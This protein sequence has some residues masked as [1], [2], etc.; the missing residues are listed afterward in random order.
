MIVNVTYET[1]GG[2]AFELQLVET[3]PNA[4]G[5]F[6]RR[7]I[8][9]KDA[10]FHAWE[11]K[12]E[13]QTVAQGV[14]VTRMYKDA[15]SYS[16]KLY[17]NGPLNYRRELLDEYHRAF[18]IDVRANTP[19]KLRW[20]D[21]WFIPCYIIASS[22]YAE[23]GVTATVNDIE[24]YCPYPFWFREDR[25]NFT[26]QAVAASTYL[27]YAYDYE[28]DYLKD[29]QVESAVENDGAG[30][31]YAVITFYGPVAN[32]RVRIGEKTYSVNYSI[33]PGE[34]V[35]IDQRE[36]TV[37]LFKADETTENLFD[38]RGKYQGYSVFDPVAVGHQPIAWGGTYRVG[39][40]LL[41]ERSEPAWN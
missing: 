14:K 28:Y 36:K 23:D 41:I 30:D 19:G 33:P 37:T 35:V 34:T 31:A 29:A 32:P 40:T 39:I 26:A 7:T 4:L 25:Y 13:A 12:P 20:N 11:Y 27:D 1:S 3:R 18:E 15:V 10:N 21:D 16:A 6:R 5:S 17:V 2:A 9:I 8:Q 24:I 22:T 38:Y